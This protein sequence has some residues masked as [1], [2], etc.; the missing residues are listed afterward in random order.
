[1]TF[2]SDTEVILNESENSADGNAPQMKNFHLMKCPVKKRFKVGVLNIIQSCAKQWTGVKLVT[3]MHV[4]A[5]VSLLA[6]CDKLPFRKYVSVVDGECTTGPSSSTGE[7]SGSLDYDHK[8]LSI[9][10][11]K[12]IDGKVFE[13]SDDVM[14]DLST[15]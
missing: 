10:N 6:S 7:N 14:A 1:M 5:V 8:N 3:G 15:D 13:V 4:M 2:K 11:F 9:V 12:P